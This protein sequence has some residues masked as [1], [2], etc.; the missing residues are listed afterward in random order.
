MSDK[1]LDI[2][3]TSL[4]N[5]DTLTDKATLSVNAILNV[6]VNL[7]HFKYKDKFYLWVDIL[8]PV[9]GQYV[10]GMV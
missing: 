5:D 4:E 6:C 9:C 8:S 7:V 3:K 1:I 2:V 10:Y